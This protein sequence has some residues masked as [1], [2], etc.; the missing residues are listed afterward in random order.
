MRVNAGNTSKAV[1]ALLLIVWSLLPV[2]QMLA[3]SL[4]P[5]DE[6]FAGTFWPRNPTLGNF[7]VVLGQD[8]FFLR[9]FWLQLGNSVFVGVATSLLVLVLASLASFSISR[10]RPGW[11]Q[12]LSGLAMV[13]YLVPSAFLCIPLYKL[14]GKLGLLN[15]RWA[16][17]LSLTAFSAPYAVWILCRYS[18]S[19]PPELDDAARLDGAGAVQLFRL[20]YL[21]LM[22]PGLVAIGVHAL[23]VAWNEYLYAFML[24]SSETRMT[25]PVMLGYF[26]VT[27]D[28][29]WNLLMATSIIYALP[30]VAIYYAARHH[31]TAGLAFSGDRAGGRP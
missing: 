20:V 7:G 24:L 11:G 26:L 30:P 23:L 29:P 1:A 9:H 18:R 2:Y 4:M 28:A 5:S 6:T 22:R 27:D 3:L 10:L 12:R 25:V 14:M 15:S 16:L 13:S 21:P 19:I 17:I 31:M 8:H